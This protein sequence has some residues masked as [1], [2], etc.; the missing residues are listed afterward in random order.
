MLNFLRLGNKIYDC[1]KRTG[2]TQAE[3]AERAG[4]SERAYA[5]IERGTA[6]ARVLSIQKICAV[7]NI[8]PNNIL[9]ENT[10]EQL[11]IEQLWSE[12]EKSS[13][14][15]KKTAMAILEAFLFSNRVNRS[16]L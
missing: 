14:E 8:E 5:D 13:L 6:N 11:S 12:L 16:P 10:N 4:L 9:T 1:R 3:V 2:L 7:L 15:E